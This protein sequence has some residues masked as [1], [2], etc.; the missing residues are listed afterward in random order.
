MNL[1]RIGCALI[2]CD[3]Q[4]FYKKSCLSLMDVCNKKN[5]DYVIINDGSEKLPYYPPYYLETGGKKG[6]AVAKN[7]GLKFLLE[8]NN[9]HIFL[10][11]DDVEIIDDTVFEKY[12]EGY[13]NT[14]ISHF[15][16]GMHGNHNKD[17]F[18]NQL[19]RKTIQYPNKT[20]IDLYPNVLGAFSYYHKSCLDAVGLLDES[21]H[22][23][24]EHVE[25]TLRIIQ[26][27]LHP[28]FRWFADIHESSKLLKDI[29]PDHKNSKIRSEEDF[30]KKFLKALDLFIKQTGFSVVQGYGPPEKN[31]TEE[32]CLKQ[33]KN[34]W[35]N[36]Q[37]KKS[38]SE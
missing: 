17:S 4:D 16:Y 27:E 25:H 22:N 6:V 28:P 14:G 5:I 12:I 35:N 19:I 33:L 11:E 31:Y 37:K 34:I 23:A 3:R 24:L 21:Y 9:E 7:L 32:E 13:K 1:E 2:T 15:N 30:Q 8:R 20:K 10:M 36:F 29:L 26:C 18:G 38:V